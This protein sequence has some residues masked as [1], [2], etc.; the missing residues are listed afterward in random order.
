VAQIYALVI[1]GQ[2]WARDPAARRERRAD[3]IA[4][5]LVATNVVGP[6]IFPDDM[7]SEATIE[8]LVAAPA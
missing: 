1:G 8:R 4:E 6:A 3:A 2:S 7:Y 5:M